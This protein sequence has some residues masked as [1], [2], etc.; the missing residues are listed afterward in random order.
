MGNFHISFY[1]NSSF[2][3]CYAQDGGII[4][5][6]F[7]FVFCWWGEFVFCVFIL[8][9]IDLRCLCFST[10]STTDF[11]ASAF[12]SKSHPL[13]SSLYRS[14]VFHLI[15]LHA[16]LCNGYIPMFFTALLFISLWPLG[17]NIKI[18]QFHTFW[19]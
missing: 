6:W 7:L 8:I 11:H 2:H 13:V 3:K 18:S 12:F 4:L 10:S 9:L 14:S 5:L 19:I 1:E 17:F 15:S 16:Y